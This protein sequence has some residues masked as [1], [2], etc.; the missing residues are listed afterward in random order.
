[1]FRTNAI[2]CGDC[3]RILRDFPE[4]CVDLI[5]V[6][7]PF[8]SNKQYEILWGNG[9]ELRSFEDRWQGD[10]LNYIAWMEPKIRESYSA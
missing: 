9:Y 3:Q 10:I 6:D 5:Y 4:E 8:F 2:Y 1:M 7:P